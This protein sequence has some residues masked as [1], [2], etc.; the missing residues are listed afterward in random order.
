MKT[1]PLNIYYVIVPSLLCVLT[2][3]IFPTSSSPTHITRLIILRTHSPTPA[4]E[5][6]PEIIKV[7]RKFL[8][9]EDYSVLICIGYIAWALWWLFVVFSFERFPFDH[10]KNP[11]SDFFLYL[12]LN[13]RGWIVNG[14]R[15]EIEQKQNLCYRLIQS[16]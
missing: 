5:H 9:I 2:V 13:P 12:R 3:T 8:L 16:V 1:S 14:G 11:I 7:K 4:F 10:L 15:V 6:F